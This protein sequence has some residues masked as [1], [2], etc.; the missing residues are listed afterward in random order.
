MVEEDNEDAMLDVARKI[1]RAK[2]YSV[3]QIKNLSVLFLTDVGKYN[4]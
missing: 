4:F 3:E 1:F 2:C